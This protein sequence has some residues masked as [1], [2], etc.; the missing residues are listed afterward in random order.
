MGFNSGFKGLIQIGVPRKQIFD[1]Y[2]KKIGLTA[3]EGTTN[4]I[5]TI[6]SKYVY[7]NMKQE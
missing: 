7:V 5:W 2:Y 3:F 6:N 4:F 1:F